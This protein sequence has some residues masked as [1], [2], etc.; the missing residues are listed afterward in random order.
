MRDA[1][2]RPAGGRPAATPPGDAPVPVVLA[3][4]RGHGAWHLENLRRLSATGLVRL[5]GVCDTVPPAPG[6]PAGFPAPAHGT[7]LGELTARTGAGIVIVCTPLHT[8]TDL[9]L[10]AAAQ[11]AH[12]LLEKPPAP[13]YA[14]Y[15]RLVAGVEAS[16]RA[17]QIGFQS[18]GS[19]ALDAVRALVAD[20][21]IG[22]VRGIGAAGNW[23]RDEHYFRRAAWSGRRRMG[24]TDVVD[25]VLTNPLAHAVATALALDGSERAEDVGAIELELFRANTIEADDT[26]ALRLRTARG[27]VVTVTAT[28]CAERN[29]EP[30]VV[31]H[32]D[33]GRVTF[34]YKQDRVLLQRAGRGPQEQRYGRTD[35]LENLVAHVRHG[36]DLLVPPRATGAFMKVVEAVRTAPDP[37]PLPDGAWR[38]EPGERSTRRVVTGVDGMVTAGAET[39]AL[40]SEL[41]APWAAPN[42][43]VRR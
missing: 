1:S 8:H 27:T 3:G 24:G 42:G 37:V 9:A 19:H 11:G 20:G 33:R 31:V 23:V 38:T 16:G 7:D 34:W 35:L 12:V 6:E 15:E 26:S 22:T 18:L 30:Y 40:F 25:G 17:C 43:V 10:A 5:A 13:S 21:A 29:A 4:A 2:T 39:L 36:E 28:L 14:A 41:G 32:G